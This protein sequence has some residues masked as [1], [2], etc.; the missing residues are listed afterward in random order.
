MVKETQHKHRDDS[1]EERI[2][3]YSSATNPSKER[4]QTKSSK[5]LILEKRDLTEK[6]FK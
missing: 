1:R 6:T 4:Y 2:A 3:R 5:E